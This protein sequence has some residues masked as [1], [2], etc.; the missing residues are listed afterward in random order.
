[1]KLPRGPI[2]ATLL[3]VAACAPHEAVPVKPSVLDQA[4]AVIPER[5]VVEGV[6][7]YAHA[8]DAFA[9][10]P[11]YVLDAAPIMRLQPERNE[12]FDLTYARTPVVLSDGRVIVV[13]A[14]NGV[15]IMQFG[16]DGVPQKLL[17][18][19]GQGPSEFVR[20]SSGL[21][22]PGDTILVV[23]DANHRRSWLVADKGTVRQAPLGAV[24]TS[25][26]TPVGVLPD[27]RFPVLSYCFGGAAGS[28]RR[29]VPLQVIDSAFTKMDTVA[30]LPGMEMVDM[31][32][33]YRGRIGKE[34]MPLRFGR[35]SFLAVWD[36]LIVTA[37][38][39]EGYVLDLRDGTGKVASKIRVA[40]P[41]RP[42]TDTMRQAQIAWEL[43]DLE[44]MR[45]ERMVDANESRRIARETPFADSLPP[46]L[47]M[48]VTQDGV[49]W[50]ADY[51]PRGS[52]TWG[53]TAFRKDGAIVARL[54]GTGKDLWPIWFGSDRVMLRQLDEDGEPTITMWRMRRK[55]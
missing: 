28:G 6:T 20:P 10:A 43:H 53:A 27:G 35:R 18:R 30:R 38:G 12:G 23:D 29:P 11:Q 40:I 41:S 54:T 44:R 26:S 51:S 34:T 5:R 31:E 8:A 15:A 25:C 55:P 7:T 33:R 52:T 36:S 14:A 47:S 50:V 3:G 16:V 46:Y 19:M 21:A 49:L 4:G 45:P 48:Q 22:L 13:K 9:R 24:Q 37:T 1:M 32:T 2:A 17:G 42:V 39:E